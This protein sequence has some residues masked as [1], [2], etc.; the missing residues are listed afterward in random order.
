[1]PTITTKTCDI[2]GKTVDE[3]VTVRNEYRVENI[4]AVRCQRSSPST[5]SPITRKGQ[6]Q[7][8]TKRGE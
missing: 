2:C 5:D 8:G 6:Q 1:M 4:V 7:K 3:L